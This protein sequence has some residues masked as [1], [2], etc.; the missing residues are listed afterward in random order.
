LTE[1]ENIIHEIMDAKGFKPDGASYD[2]DSDVYRALF[3]TERAEAAAVVMV[4]GSELRRNILDEHKAALAKS[5]CTNALVTWCNNHNI[6]RHEF[7]V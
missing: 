7:G 2:A 1:V 5:R 6:P 3:K 4:S